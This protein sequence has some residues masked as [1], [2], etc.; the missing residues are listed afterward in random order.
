MRR[1]FKPYRN[2][3]CQHRHSLIPHT[4]RWST[5][6]PLSCFSALRSAWSTLRRSRRA[7]R[8]RKHHFRK[9]ALTRAEH[10]CIASRQDNNRLDPS[11]G[12]FVTDCDSTTYCSD[13]GTCVAKTCRHDIVSL[14]TSPN[15]PLLTPLQ[16]PFGYNGVPFAELPPLCASDQFCPDE[17]DGCLPRVAQ[18][19]ACQLDRD[20]ESLKQFGGAKL[21]VEGRS[22]HRAIELERTGRRA[23]HQRISLPQLCLLVSLPPDFSSFRS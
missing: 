8:A 17:G 5:N 16:F 7:E 10:H 20:G 15:S 11:T 19:E 2:H 21:M 6:P 3:H 12:N 18:G 9:P 13:N 22:M 23:E 4:S 14:P 1:L